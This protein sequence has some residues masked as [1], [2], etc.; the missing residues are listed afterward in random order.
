VPAQ[1]VAKSGLLQFTVQGNR[2]R[3]WFAGRPVGDVMDSADSV[4]SGPG[5]AGLRG[6]PG[7][8]FSDFLASAP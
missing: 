6:G 8:V 4:L 3:L 5:L 1:A 2:L 7:A